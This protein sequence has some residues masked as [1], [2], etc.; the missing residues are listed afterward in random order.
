V[1]SP[2]SVSALLDSYGLGPPTR[3][4]R[5]L[6]R[7]PSANHSAGRAE[8]RFQ[9]C[10]ANRVTGQTVSPRRS[11]PE[12]R[13]PRRPAFRDENLP[14]NHDG[15]PSAD[16]HLR[17][18]PNH[19][20]NRSRDGSQ[21][22]SRKGCLSLVWRGDCVNMRRYK[23]I[24]D[25]AIRLRGNPAKTAVFGTMADQTAAGR[26]FPR[27]AVPVSVFLVPNARLRHSSFGIRAFLVGF[28][29]LP[30][31]RELAGSQLDEQRRGAR[32][33]EFRGH[34]T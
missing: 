4:R 10:G 14:R 20:E 23:E 34:L 19:P 30:R 6:F 16:A 15:R 28:H 1:V 7:S 26:G 11:L 31:R 2:R 33:G 25:K 29:H 17:P 21:G 8:S 3:R 32:L 22:G 9:N 24:G 5:N 27:P 13:F 12:S 18:S